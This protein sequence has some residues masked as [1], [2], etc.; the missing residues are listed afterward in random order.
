MTLLGVPFDEGDVSNWTLQSVRTHVESSKKKLKA[1][2]VNFFG[3]S[4]DE[5]KEAKDR[6]ADELLKHF[7]PLGR[8]PSSGTEAKPRYTVQTSMIRD[9]PQLFIKRHGPNPPAWFDVG[10]INGSPPHMKPFDMKNV[11]QQFISLTRNTTSHITGPVKRQER[12]KRKDRTDEDGDNDDDDNNT[13]NIQTLA[14]QPRT[15]WLDEI[16]PFPTISST[17]SS[18]SQSGDRKLLGRY[19]NPSGAG[20]LSHQVTNTLGSRT[21]DH[22]HLGLILY[23]TGVTIIDQTLI[24]ERDRFALVG[25]LFESGQLIE[26]RIQELVFGNPLDNKLT[27]LWF[28]DDTSDDKPR[29]IRNRLSAEAAIMMLKARADRAGAIAIQLFDAPDRETAALIPVH[30]VTRKN[31][32]VQRVNFELEIDNDEG[33]REDESEIT[34]GMDSAYES[35]DGE[36]QLDDQPLIEEIDS[37]P[38]IIWEG[39][40]QQVN[41]ESESESEEE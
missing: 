15:S 23:V 16:A 1:F 21:R 40:Q 33:G 35:R 36:L 27:F 29:V 12:L 24:L 18:S 39:Q 3:W 25:S 30:E 13:S 32:F 41:V 28:F 9:W 22:S 17:T 6:T 38:N 11:I 34:M 31:D 20:N 37:K 26:Q 8:F 2:Y 4:E 19:P 14:K 10:L 7:D 5:Y